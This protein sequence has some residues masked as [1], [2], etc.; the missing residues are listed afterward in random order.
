MG[1]RFFIT[2]EQAE[3]SAEKAGAQ[4]NQEVKSVNAN[5][6]LII[7]IDDEANVREGMQG[8]LQLWGCNVITAAS[9]EEAITQLKQH[10]LV[11]HGIIADY[12]LRDNQTGIDAIHGIHKEYHNNIPALIVTGDIAVDRLRVVNDS[13]FQVLHKP[14]AP[15][16]LRTFLHNVQLNQ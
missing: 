12:R 3:V 9:K 8:L 14:V 4:P 2:V 16:K 10:Q 13:G 7:V 15:M 5:G 11:P 6:T 1:S